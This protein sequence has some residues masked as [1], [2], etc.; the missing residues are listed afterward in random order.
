MNVPKSTSL[1][2]SWI[3]RLNIS[4]KQ[5]DQA[6]PWKVKGSLVEETAVLFTV[7]KGPCLSRPIN[8]PPWLFCFLILNFSWSP[9]SCHS[10]S[11]SFKEPVICSC[12]CWGHSI[13]SCALPR[14]PFRSHWL[15][16]S[17]TTH[18][19]LPAS[20]HR[21]PGFV[22]RDTLGTVCQV[23]SSGTAHKTV[24]E[25]KNKRWVFTGQD[26]SVR[27]WYPC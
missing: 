8:S 3:L 11:A 9:N 2:I 15:D 16:L 25:K 6:W 17:L 14:C 22:R 23:T 13:L 26:F 5:T 10:F 4:E 20:L 21:N 19:E 27:F 12:F 1:V 24:K 18:P 7:I